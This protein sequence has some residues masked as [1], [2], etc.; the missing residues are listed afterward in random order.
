[1]QDVYMK[2]NPG[3][4]MQKQHSSKRRL[5]SPEN[6]TYVVGKKLV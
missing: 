6:W 1:M 2:L 3:L 5:F 4:P